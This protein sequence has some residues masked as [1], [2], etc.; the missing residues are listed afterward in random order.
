M[1]KILFALQSIVILGS[2]EFC[3]NIFSIESVDTK[4]NKVSTLLETKKADTI[5]TS[6]PSET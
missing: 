3:F 1:Q 5:D 4:M 2:W 6:I